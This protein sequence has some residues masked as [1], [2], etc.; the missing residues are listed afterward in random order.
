M[1]HGMDSAASSSAAY[2]RQSRLP[3]A[4]VAVRKLRTLGSLEI[5]DQNAFVDLF[6]K[7]QHV[8][9]G[10][11]IA[12]DGSSPAASACL[13]SGFA[14][15]YKL[16]AGGRRQIY[17]VQIGGDILNIDSYIC[18][19]M[20]QAIGALTNCVVA[21]LPHNKIEEAIRHFPNLGFLLWRSSLIESAACRQWLTGVARKSG[22]G[23][24]AHFFC[25]HVT[26]MQAVGLASRQKASLPLTQQELSDCLGL[27]LV[28]TN[29]VLQ[30]LRRM[31]VVELKSKT[32]TVLD[33]AKLEDL[34]EFD[35]AYLRIASEQDSTH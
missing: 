10:A 8:A 29:R 2:F 5:E 3:A 20:D 6:E 16:L 4:N 14:C 17:S 7:P 1:E 9:A 31:Q 13:I 25:E 12:Q 32:V 19:R 33:R 21:M 24:L 30:E 18:N 35:A 27:S 34:G 11:D 15:R 26:R 22:L 23:R 28:H